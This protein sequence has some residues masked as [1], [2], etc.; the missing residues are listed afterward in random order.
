M[1][2]LAEKRDSMVAGD[3]GAALGPIGFQGQSHWWG[4]SFGHHP[5]LNIENIEN[6]QNYIENQ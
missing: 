1:S 6:I 2:R 4:T 5:P 3:V